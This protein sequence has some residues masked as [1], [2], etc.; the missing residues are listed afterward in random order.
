MFFQLKNC[1]K[2]LAKINNFPYSSIFVFNNYYWCI[3][4][5]FFIV[6]A[7]KIMYNKS[8]FYKKA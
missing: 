5:D 3:I 4:V 7:K 1:T 6:I 2:F 8:I